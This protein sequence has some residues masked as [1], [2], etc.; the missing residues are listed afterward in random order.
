MK[1]IRY[2][3][4]GFGTLINKSGEFG[5]GLNDIYEENG[6]GKTTFIAFLKAMF[7]GMDSKTKKGILDERKHYRPW[8][9]NVSFGG[10]LVFE[11]NGRRYRVVRNFGKKDTD[12]LFEIYNDETGLISNDYTKDLGEEIFMVDKE[13]F[14]KTAFLS[15]NDEN[16]GFLSDVIS[17][18]ISG[19]GE[20]DADLSK[21]DLAI[22]NLEDGKKNLTG[23]IRGSQKTKNNNLLLQ[24][25]AELN[26]LN[27]LSLKKD[28]LSQNI[29]NAKNLTE[30]KTAELKTLRETIAKNEKFRLLLERKKLINKQKAAKAKYE[31]LKGSFKEIPTKEN[32]SEFN[33]N[34]HE[35]ENKLLYMKDYRLSVDEQETYHDNNQKFEDSSKDIVR[36]LELLESN[37]KAYRKAS[38]NLVKYAS[39]KE[40][41]ERLN[42]LN[43]IYADKETACREIED[44]KMSLNR[45]K[46]LEAE[47]ALLEKDMFTNDINM[48]TPE[49]NNIKFAYI[50]DGICVFLVI[51][52]SLLLFMRYKNG[53][54]MISALL[55]LPLIS[56]AAAIVL[57]IA[58]LLMKKRYRDAQKELNEKKEELTK[59]ELKIE[60]NTELKDA[61]DRNIITIL[62]KYGKNGDDKERLLY[63]ALADIDKISDL[64]NEIS[65]EEESYLNAQTEIQNI[66]EESK[67]ILTE[68]RIFS[69]DISEG[70]RKLEKL[71]ASYKQ[72]KDKYEKYES[73][74]GEISAL[75]NAL[76]D[77]ILR[78]FNEKQESYIKTYEYQARAYD[79]YMLAKATY[80][81]V[82]AEL[83][84]RRSE[85]NVD[86][87]KASEVSDDYEILDLDELRVKEENL[88]NDIGKLNSDIKLYEDELNGILAEL[89]DEPELVR[90]IEKLRE[91]NELLDK[92][93]EIYEQAQNYLNQART[94][95]QTRY[96]DDV[97]HRYRHY[98]EPLVQNSAVRNETSVSTSLEINVSEGAVNE[99]MDSLSRGKQDLVKFSLRMA[100][101]DSVY[102]DCEK[103][104]VV[105]DD[106]FVNFDDNT[107]EAAKN[108]IRSISEDYQV[109]YFTCHSSR[110]IN[111]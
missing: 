32:M 103:P 38:D 30:E 68:Y 36:D 82:N 104:F 64:Q 23:N 89:D 75:K 17:S 12:D 94:N 56:Y 14:T 84:K 34:A 92:K 53:A 66:T 7:Y 99:K 61:L 20:E 67:Q 70:T 101:I 109:L 11:M 18:R 39:L 50:L 102:R 59:K 90:D 58:S 48:I 22:K 81:S 80:E 42:N 72:A 55:P 5:D 49:V 47:S 1:L 26:R 51:I 41:K 108:E 9:R 93:A 74:S 8:N 100:L 15:Q 76:E 44:A 2:D 85:E 19:M 46:E 25:E 86:E 71:Y 79:E 91:D 24:K 43:N 33:K 10:S 87:E 110:Q 69:D 77:A 107:L 35:Y 106:P 13:S 4:S 28:P 65:K 62:S 27:E 29:I 54:D 3:I 88:N 37:E 95:I 21:C 111:N 83:E 78:F 6:V 105:L 57:F 45:I 73:L 96:I 31:E 16:T 97:S 40:K 98:Y 63:E 60:E 52:G